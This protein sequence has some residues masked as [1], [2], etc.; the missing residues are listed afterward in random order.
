MPASD[1]ASR[2]AR[3]S[4]VGPQYQSTVARSLEVQARQRA[5]GPDALEHVVHGLA[6]AHE[7]V[8]LVHGSRKRSQ[9]CRCQGSSLVGSRLSILL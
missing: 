1:S 6:V 2:T 3:T 7:G 5:L 8:V 4:L 9:V